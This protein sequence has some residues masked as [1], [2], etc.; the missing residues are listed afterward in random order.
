[1][2]PLSTSPVIVPS[3]EPM[4]LADAIAHLQALSEAEFYEAARIWQA[5]R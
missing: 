2:Y 5:A 3:V 4:K 1:M